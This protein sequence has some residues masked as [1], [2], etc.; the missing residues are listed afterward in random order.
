MQHIS[1]LS[2][3]FLYIKIYMYHIREKLATSVFIVPLRTLEERS[4]QRFDTIDRVT[5][6]LKNFT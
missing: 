3:M 5:L 1:I 6:I 4:A 2:S